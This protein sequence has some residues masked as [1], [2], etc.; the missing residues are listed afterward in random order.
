MFYFLN[1]MFCPPSNQEDLLLCQPSQLFTYV[2]FSYKY[3]FLFFLDYLEELLI[4]W[5]KRGVRGPSTQQLSLFY[6]SFQQN[7][8]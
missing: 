4:E 2:K 1:E 6:L 7:E 5:L 3:T 8:K